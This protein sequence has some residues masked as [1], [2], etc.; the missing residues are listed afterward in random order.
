M[1]SQSAP[2]FK[3]AFQTGSVGS[4]ASMTVFYPLDQIRSV[5]QVGPSID[6]EIRHPQRQ[7]NS[8]P[9]I[10]GITIRFFVDGATAQAQ[11]DVHGFADALRRILR[12][13]GFKGLYE[14]RCT[15]FTPYH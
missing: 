10:I 11:D 14:A 12:N 6:G 7:I 1:P 9:F 4:I 3:I 2:T 8:I 5:L 15:H 13:K